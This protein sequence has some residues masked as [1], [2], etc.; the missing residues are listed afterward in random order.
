MSTVKFLTLNVRGLRNQEKRRSIFSYLEKQKANIYLLQETFSNP[1]DE[2]IWSAE[3]GG[4]IFYS[5]GSEHSKGVCVLIKPNSL[6]QV[7]IVELD[8]NGRYIIL[9]LKTPGETIFNIVN[10]YAPTNYRE[11]IN[12]IELLTKKIIS[13]TDLSNLIIAGDWNAT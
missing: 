8:T 4:Q 11:Q 1:K 5:H 7:D 9:R 10:I 2:R 13:L 6:F 12:F 3:W